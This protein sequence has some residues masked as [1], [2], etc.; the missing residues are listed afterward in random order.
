MKYLSFDGHCVDSPMTLELVCYTTI[1]TNLFTRIQ[2]SKIPISN[3]T[4]A[5]DTP[6]VSQ[7]IRH[8]N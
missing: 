6:N 7:V 8:C 2:C 5:T 4:I 1:S 3:D